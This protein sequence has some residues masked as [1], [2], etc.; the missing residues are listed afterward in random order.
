M[1]KTHLILCCLIIIT[2]LSG[3]KSCKE[4]LPPN[5]TVTIQ[6]SSNLYYAGEIV[7]YT[8]NA[9]SENALNKL[10]ITPSVVGNNRD[11]KI[12]SSV[13]TQQIIYKYKYVVP[14]IYEKTTHKN[15]I[16]IAFKVIQD[17]Q[18]EAVE[19]LYFNIETFYYNLVEY[20][21]F[22]LYSFFNPENKACFCS[23]KNKTTYNTETAPDF[24]EKIDFA[25]Y[26]NEEDSSVFISPDDEL[27]MNFE[28]GTITWNY[29]KSTR[30]K[31]TNL[32]YQDFENIYFDAS[33]IESI[34]SYDMTESKIAK[35]KSNEI[36]AFKN[37]NIGG[38]ISFGIHDEEN[39]ANIS[40][41]I[42]YIYLD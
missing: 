17:D 12:D 7:Y 42:K 15:L 29:R 8:I 2:L 10:I 22:D 35:L 25:Y 40:M 11:S 36:I 32:S 9:N 31:K 16:S 23:I 3:C 26:F 28:N 14:V 30:F 13:N 4:N 39:N 6:D 37:E 38:I 19:T 33:E 34:I 5:L 27:I 18:Q 1:K 24:A 41:V 20:D 21:Y